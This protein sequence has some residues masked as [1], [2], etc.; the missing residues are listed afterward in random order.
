MKANNSSH[1]YLYAK[2][3]YKRSEDIM[4]DLK[5]LVANYCGLYPEHIGYSDISHRL[6]SL[7]QNEFPHYSSG[8]VFYQLMEDILPENTWKFGYYH[9]SMGIGNLLGMD[10]KYTNEYDV[11]YAIV[12]KCL[13]ILT[14]AETQHIEGGICA[15]DFTLLEPANEDIIESVKKHTWSK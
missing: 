2:H 10:T 13:S 5:V 14:Q 15:P 7:I 4:Q 11:H 3:W 12:G 8:Y 1:F 9:N 6:L